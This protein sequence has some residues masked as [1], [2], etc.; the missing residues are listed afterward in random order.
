MVSDNEL[1]RDADLDQVSSD[2]DESMK[3]CRSMVADYRAFLTNELSE[4]EKGSNQPR[5]FESGANGN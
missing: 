5:T 3:T 1:P 2:L 4:G